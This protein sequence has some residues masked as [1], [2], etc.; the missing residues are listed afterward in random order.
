MMR[1]QFLGKPVRP[2]RDSRNSVDVG[3]GSPDESLI[4]PASRVLPQL[5]DMFPEANSSDK[6]MR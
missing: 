5:A 4:R 2:F 6:P 3:N 1:I